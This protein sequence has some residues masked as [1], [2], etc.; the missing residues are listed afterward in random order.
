VSAP[1]P[2]KTDDLPALPAHLDPVCTRFEAACKA[3]PAA[4]PLPRPEDYFSDTAPPERALLL[5]E[6][7]ALDIAYRRQ[8]GE[9]PTASDYCHRFPGLDAAWLERECR[10]SSAG[11][12][13]APQGHK[14]RC[15]HCQNPILLTDEQPDEILCPGCSS[16]FRLREARHTAT[17]STSR[18]LGKFVLLERVGVGA[19]GAVWKARDTELDRIVALKIPMRG[20]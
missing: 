1:D 9:T 7:V 5:R 18:P 15:P 4:A 19:F 20:C 16:S 8:R 14:V 3:T 13:G 12:E 2:G 10:T 11:T 17:T 6:L